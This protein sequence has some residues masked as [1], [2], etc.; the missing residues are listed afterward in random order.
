MVEQKHQKITSSLFQLKRFFFRQ[1]TMVKPYEAYVQPV[2]YYGALIYGCANKTDLKDL[3]W[4]QNKILKNLKAWE[5]WKKEKFIRF[6]KY[7]F[8]SC[9]K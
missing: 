4:S 5:N 2:I 8:M 6:T 1:K 7:I 9:S 3:E